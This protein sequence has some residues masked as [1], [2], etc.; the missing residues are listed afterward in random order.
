M[1]LRHFLAVLIDE[2]TG[3]AVIGERR[4]KAYII[5]HAVLAVLF[6]LGIDNVCVFA[7]YDILT[8]PASAAR[9]IVFGFTAQIQH[10]APLCEGTLAYAFFAR[11]HY[12]VGKSVAFGCFRQQ[13]SLTLFAE[14]LY[15]VTACIACRHQTFSN[16]SMFVTKIVAPPTNTSTG[17]LV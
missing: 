6:T 5:T 17:K 1:L 16:L 10:S 15:A 11:Q 13:S 8:A 4:S 3:V 12:S 9:H 7:R 2:N 14:Q